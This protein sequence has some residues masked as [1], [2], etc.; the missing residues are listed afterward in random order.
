[1]NIAMGKEVKAFKQNVHE[2]QDDP[3]G[4]V[5][6][7]LE[8]KLRKNNIDEEDRKDVIEE[9]VKNRGWFKRFW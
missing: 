9:K 4:A 3:V 8:T 6:A 1:M 2:R 7:K 5:I